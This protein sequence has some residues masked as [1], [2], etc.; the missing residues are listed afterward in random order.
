MRKCLLE[1]DAMDYSLIHYFR[2]LPLRYYLAGG[3]LS[4]DESSV[5]FFLSPD[6]ASVL[7]IRRRSIVAYEDQIGEIAD[8]PPIPGIPRAPAAVTKTFAA[9]LFARNRLNGL[10]KLILVPDFGAED[11]Y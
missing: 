3:L 8:H 7:I 4:R 11:L 1:T 6:N 9:K 5:L 10:S 2:N